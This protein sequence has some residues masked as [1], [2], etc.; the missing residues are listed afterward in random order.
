[1]RKNI[2][3]WRKWS[4]MNSLQLHG[5]QLRIAT[6][7][8]EQLVEGGRMVYSTCSLNPI[9]DEAVIA[10]LLDKSEGALEL[11]DVSSELPGLRW[12]PGLTHWKVMTKDGQWFAEW[13]DVPQS[14]HTQIRPTMF[15]PSPPEQLQS[16]HLER[17]LRILPHHQNTGGFFVAVLV[18]KAA[19]PWS[20]R[21]R[22]VQGRASE[23]RASVQPCPAEPTGDGATGPSEQEPKPETAMGET[24]VL[25][26]D[27]NKRDGVCGPPP[28]KK[29]KLFGFKEDPFVFIPE[30]DP[31][32]PPIQKFYALDP[33][34]PKTN[35]LTR[36]TEGKKRQLYMVSKELRN[37]LLNNSEKMKVINT[38]IKVWCRNNCGE[39]FDC[40]F[41]LAQ[42]G[43]Y[44]LFPFINSRIVR[45][46]LEDVKVLLTQENPFFR[47]LSNEAQ[48]QVK[49]LAKGSIVLKYEPDPT[50]PDTLQCPIVLC[51]WR[52]KTSVRTFV[53][54]NE[55][56]HYLRMMGLEGAVDV[57]AEG[58]EENKASD[59][60]A[61]SP[62]P[63][64]EP[65]VSTDAPA[66]DMPTVDKP[67]VATST[68]SGASNTAPDNPTDAASPR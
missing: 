45:V 48:R 67:A 57:Q 54:K 11:V 5:L 27:E 59:D 15:P 30:D 24:D 38:G 52:G 58:S 10:S 29:M 3:V 61:A 66:M 7:G 53:P 51:G 20:G 33:S 31:L 17:C 37:V 50:S 65:K 47:K 41:R 62:A 12:M 9:E 22:N 25:E 68:A 2:D 55:R 34:F 14:R 40:A 32:F 63:T 23:P 18:K 60:P 19:M 35:L 8:A 46:S 43:I 6:R 49:D 16:L 56:L 36:T 42:E 13:A 21:Q 39:D 26:S 1:M 64:Q 4:T 28:S 44:T